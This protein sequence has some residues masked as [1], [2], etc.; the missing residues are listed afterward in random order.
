MAN[1]VKLL[2]N[3][4]LTYLSLIQHNPPSYCVVT[5]R[6]SKD[7]KF[8]NKPNYIFADDVTARSKT[9]GRKNDLL[10]H[11]NKLLL[12]HHNKLYV[13]NPQACLKKRVLSS[14]ILQVKPVMNS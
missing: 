7:S 10:S 12:S 8:Y 2:H 5:T 4:S 14:D 13:S 9:E 1:G 11:H 6:F 3:Q